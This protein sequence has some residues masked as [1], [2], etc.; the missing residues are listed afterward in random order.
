[1]NMIRRLIQRLRERKLLKQLT[2]IRQT[3]K[4]VSVPVKWRWYLKAR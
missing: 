3:G 4:V 2:R 1:M